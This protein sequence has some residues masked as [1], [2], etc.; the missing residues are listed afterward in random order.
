MKKDRMI[1]MPNRRLVPINLEFNFQKLL[2]RRIDVDF[3]WGNSETR[4]EHGTLKE[5]YKDYIM[6]ISENR[7]RYI[8][9]N[10]IVYIETS[11]R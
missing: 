2:N 9:K 1:A 8:P 4:D 10:K 11:R 5:V 3:D 7:E 6:I